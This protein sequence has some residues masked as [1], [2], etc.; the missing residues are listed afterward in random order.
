MA[1]WLKAPM[2]LSEKQGWIT[3]MI[4]WPTATCHSRSRG[5][6]TFILPPQA[7]G[8]DVTQEIHAGKTPIYIK[9]K[10]KVD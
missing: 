3:N 5:S 6:N 10:L 9:I 1:Q 7:P 8:R 4:Q 2:A